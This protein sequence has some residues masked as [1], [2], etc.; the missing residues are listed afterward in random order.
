MTSKAVIIDGYIDE[1]ACFGVPPYISPYIRYAAGAFE[2]NGISAGY[3]TVDQ[4]RKDP[5][6]LQ[7]AQNADYVLLITGVSVP[8]KYLGGTPAKAAEILQIGSSLNRPVTIVGG[9]VVFGSSKGGGDAAEKQCFSPFD[10]VLE[11]E[12]GSAVDSVIREGESAGNFDYERIDEFAVAGA[13]IVQKHPNYPDVICEL[14]TARGC[15]RYVSGGC[16]FC[17]EFLYGEP[18]FRS[19]AGVHAEVKA[20]YYSG[21]RHFRV[22]RQPDLLTYGVRGGEFPCPDPEKIEHLFSGIRGA[23]LG[24]KTLHIDNINPRN[25]FEHEEAAKEALKAIVRWHTPGDVAAFG[26]ESADPVVVRENNLKALPEQVMR[27]IEIVNEVGG[28]REN[29]IPHLLPGLN[30]VLGL[31]GES[32]ATYDLN[33]WFLNEV[34]SSGLLVRRVN[35]RQV[36][37]FEGTKAW[38]ENSIGMYDDLFRKFKEY[39][40]KNFDHP[41]LMKVF[42][43]GTILRD[44]IIEEEGNTSF[45]RQMGSYPILV[46]VPQ[47]IVK[48]EH[49]DAVVAGWGQRS[50]TGFQYPIRMNEVTVQTIKQI[51]GIGKKTAASIAAKRPF[52]DLAGLH[53][54]AGKT[55]LDEFFSF[56]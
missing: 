18:K 16:S 26:M 34:L 6:L 39:A 23:A 37:P 51:P 13:G 30:F 49:L 3:L 10:F 41:M 5:Y 17:T 11:G 21:V 52:K 1:P 43:R 9:P 46:G 8:G 31:K 2:M 44:V 29:G 33:L 53:K 36:M 20:L 25:I 54:V 28:M 12:I 47:K 14:E 27:A 24:L 32:P 35:I 19:P 56:E 4:V 22:G 40:R 45:G 50:T 15:S 55:E 38:E 42:P 48:G 7:N